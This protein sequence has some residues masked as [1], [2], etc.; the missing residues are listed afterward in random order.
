[1]NSTSAASSGPGITSPNTGG[2]DCG[3]LMDQCSSGTPSHRPS[4]SPRTPAGARSE[5]G[6]QR[7]DPGHAVLTRRRLGHPILLQNRPDAAPL[8]TPP[9]GAGSVDNVVHGAPGADTP[10]VARP[11]SG[12]QAAGACQHPTRMAHLHLCAEGP[13]YVYRVALQDVERT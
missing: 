10:G 11:W 5:R 13:P 9:A 4:A 2:E 3:Y 7:S 12:A 8:G 6:P 1:M